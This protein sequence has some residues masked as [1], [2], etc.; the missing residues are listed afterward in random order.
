MAVYNDHRTWTIQSSEAVDTLNAGTGA[1]YKAIDAAGGIAPDKTAIGILQYAGGNAEH[2]TLAV[3][4]ITKYVAGGAITGG[5]RVS[6]TT[7]GYLV[8]A[9]SGDFTQ[10][11]NLE[12]S[13]ASGAV[14]VGLFNFAIPHTVVDCLDMIV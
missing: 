14:G 5:G 6:V 12:T 3:D 10:G 7:S 11:R 13:V 2:I 9:D 8:A 1:L 4:G